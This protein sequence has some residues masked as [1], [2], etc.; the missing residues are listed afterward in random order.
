MSKTADILKQVVAV[1][2]GEKFPVMSVIR[3]NPAL[4]AAISKL[5]SDGQQPKYGKG[6]QRELM[7]PNV[8]AFRGQSEKTMNEIKDAEGVMQILPD[9]ELSAQILISSILSPKD[10]VT[11]ELLFAGPE[12]VLPN[13]VV[14]E[15]IALIRKHFEQTYKIKNDLELI[16]RDML[17]EKG[18]HIRLV[19]PE[20]SLDEFINR[21]AP[22]A[23]AMESVNH[24]YHE[25]FNTDGTPKPLG[26][27][28]NGN[29]AVHEAESAMKFENFAQ[30][31]DTTIDGVVAIE[32]YKDYDDRGAPVVNNGK[33]VQ[34]NDYLFV[35]DNFAVLST[36]RAME[37]L[38][39]LQVREKLKGKSMSIATEGFD[40]PMYEQR[41]VVR[42][43]L[44]DRELTSALFKNANMKA[45]NVSSLK[46]QQQ[47]KRTTIGNP[48]VLELPTEAVIPVHVPGQPEKHVG[49]FVLLDNTGHPI[50][51][52]NRADYYSDLAGRMGTNIG[53]SS[54][55]SQ[56]IAR[57]K[58]MMG[59]FDC[60]NSE[61]LDYS[62]RV[63]GDLITAD[64]LARLRNGIYTNGVALGTNDDV[65]RIM[66]ARTL[67]QQ[68]T[69]ILFVPVE[70]VTYFAFR[71]NA[72]GIG[73]SILS[74]T[75]IINA[76]RSTLM[77]ANVMAAIRNSI[78]MTSVDFKLDPEDPDP[79][80]SLEIMMSEVLRSRQQ[81]FPLNTSSPADIVYQLQ[82]GGYQFTYSDHPGLPDVKVEFGERTSNYPKPDTDLEES[83]R[84]RSIMAYG[85]NPET[86][87]TA[88][89][90]EFATTVTQ[91][92]IM[93][94]RRVMQLQD[95][96]TPLLTSHLVKY[97]RASEVLMTQIADLVDENYDTIKIPAEIE[98]KFNFGEDIDIRKKVEKSIIVE[99]LTEMFLDGM[100]ITLP[101]P[102]TV[103][104]E[105]QATAFDAYV[106]LLD[107]AL[108]AWLNKEFFSQ[109]LT[110]DITNLVDS[111]KASV[112]A[113]YIRKWFSDNGVM[114]ELA[115]MTAQDSEGVPRIQF[116]NEQKTHIESLMKS[117]AA[118]GAGLKPMIEATDKVAGDIGLDAGGGMGGGF[119]GAG[120][121]FGGGSDFGGGGAGGNDFGMDTGGGDLSLPGEGGSDDGLG[122]PTGDDLAD[123]NAGGNPPGNPDDTEEPGSPKNPEDQ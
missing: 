62:A 122:D 37:G 115:E 85:L 92:N 107:Q 31:S 120:G 13:Q 71:Y 91:N 26:F 78:G 114:P 32:S 50:S 83:L 119:G 75:K 112:K 10:M 113:Y 5:R 99:H 80:K 45:D 61:H 54:L 104:I 65:Y 28:G 60:S 15:I 43:K 55:P 69:Q 16:L 97:I 48:L 46:T 17:F 53:T 49:Y 121:G 20:N 23:V 103:T 11:V 38:R 22:L 123:P 73:R 96:F 41:N 89:S 93:L 77:F 110:G 76:L 9:I 1:D 95:R 86:V 90:G 84:K 94:T 8:M 36:P 98:E 58:S 34:R 74:D 105:N 6:G 57:T 63:Y 68:R 19:L 67:Q 52:K 117:L 21:H 116:W 59:G 44:T 106:K 111:V 25:V 102:D 30:A 79:T 109:E 3:S 118:L 12:G 88:F 29:R 51:V 101:R 33:A 42:Q 66:L 87:D 70:L 82:R 100:E 14:M 35:T 72:D 2:D 4:A 47:L 108:E 56:V 40:Q 27:L 24:G 39:A 81:A 18:A 64:L 7:A